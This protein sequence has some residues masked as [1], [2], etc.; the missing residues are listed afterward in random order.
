[1]DLTEQFLP[2]YNKWLETVKHLLPNGEEKK[3][4]VTPENNN[5]AETDLDLAKKFYDFNNLPPLKCTFLGPGKAVKFSKVTINTWLIQDE[6][7][8]QWYIPQW[9]VFTQPQNNFLGFNNEKPNDG[10]VY[11][12]TYKGLKTLENKGTQH[13]CEVLK[14]IPY[15]SGGK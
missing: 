10:H 13:I 3:E 14:K 1:M 15:G 4:S 7:G 6:N 9:L 8:Y 5:G 11:L 12:I 2:D